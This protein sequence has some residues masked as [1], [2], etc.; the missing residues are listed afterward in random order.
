MAAGTIVTLGTMIVLE[1]QAEQRFDGIYANEP[2]YFG[3]IASAL[4]F[5]VVSLITRPTSAAVITRWNARVAG[6]A[7]AEGAEIT[8]VAGR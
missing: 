5:I 3:L 6:H 7:D 1:I 2:I 8:E 4:T